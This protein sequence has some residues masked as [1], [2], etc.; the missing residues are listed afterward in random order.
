MFKRC[1]TCQQEWPTR[2]AFLI[3]PAT[4]LIGY[5]ANFDRLEEGFFL[6]NHN[7]RDC[8]TT[9]AIVTGD[10]LDCY[11]GPHFEVSCRGTDQCAR[12]CMNASSLDRCPAQCECAYVRHVLHLIRNWPK[13]AVSVA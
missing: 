8:G 12:L 11:Q 1:T 5:Q 4:V 6:F 10:F 9:L 13:M 7:T 2:E 3:D